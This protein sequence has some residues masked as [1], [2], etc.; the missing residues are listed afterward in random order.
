[1]PSRSHGAGCRCRR[2]RRNVRRHASATIRPS[3]TAAGPPPMPNPSLLR[4]FVQRY[5]PPQTVKCDAKGLPRD[6]Y[7][8]VNG[9][10]TLTSRAVM[11]A[12]TPFAFSTPESVFRARSPSISIPYRVLCVQRVCT[13][14]VGPPGWAEMPRFP[15]FQSISARIGVIAAAL[16]PAGSSPLLPSENG[17]LGDLP[18]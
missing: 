8:A 14:F 10:I 13:M 5:R 9:L 11:K 3:S 16:R 1:M 7:K 12:I 17:F 6:I 4:T 15:V 2:R 18:L